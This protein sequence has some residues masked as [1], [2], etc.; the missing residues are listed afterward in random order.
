ME[1]HKLASAII[2]Q[3]K[4]HVYGYLALIWSKA[5]GCAYQFN[6]HI[7]KRKVTLGIKSAV[8]AKRGN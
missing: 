4:L 8:K 7:A 2:S 5:Y 3:I 1:V 6:R